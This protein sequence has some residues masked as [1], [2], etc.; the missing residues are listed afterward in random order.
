MIHPCQSA[1]SNQLAALRVASFASTETRSS[2][3]GGAL[4]LDLDPDVG[5]V[6][7]SCN[8]EPGMIVA[9]DARIEGTPR[10]VVLRLDLGAGVFRPGDVLGLT[11]QASAARNC[12]VDVTL[13]TTK[14]GDSADLR[15]ADTL[16]LSPRKEVLTVLHTLSGTDPVCGEAKSASLLLHLPKQDFRMTLH[17][18]HFFI[19][20][21]ELG[22]RSEP[23]RLS[24]FSA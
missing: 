14:N 3:L 24:S 16:A 7:M 15:F 1:A 6:T 20:P 18:M 12:Q 4:R 2:K 9:L 11:M 21:A 22:L 10:W 13:R 23:M 8:S 17:D 19:L 5:K